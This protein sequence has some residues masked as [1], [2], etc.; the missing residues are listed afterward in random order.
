MRN[1]LLDS[2]TR[3]TPGPA[4]TSVSCVPSS[5][6]SGIL[7]T[8]QQLGIAVGIAVLV[9]AT[10]VNSTRPELLA[11]SYGTG[12]PLNA[13]IAVAGAIAAAAGSRTRAGVDAGPSRAETRSR[14]QL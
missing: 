10:A 2:C 1:T 11:S 12:L 14:L 8:A 9:S 7:N 3:A 6:A 13:F 4:A 5:P